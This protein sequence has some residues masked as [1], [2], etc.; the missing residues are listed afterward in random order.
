MKFLQLARRVTLL[1]VVNLLVMVTLGIIASLLLGG[2]A[3]RF[4]YDNLFFFCFIFGMG[5][6]FFSLAISRWMAK[7][8]MGVQVIDPASATPG[9]QR[10]VESSIIW[11][12]PPVSRPCRKWAY[13][14]RLRLTPSPP[15]RASR[16]RWLRFLPGL[17]GRMKQSDIE[18]VPGPRNRRT[19]PTAT[20]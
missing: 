10:L 15:A 14:I 18:G 11:P 17:L 7:T 16:A 20:W 1:I 6:A 19:S 3:A 9:E 13:I 4:G 5:G 8:M 12:A 2:R